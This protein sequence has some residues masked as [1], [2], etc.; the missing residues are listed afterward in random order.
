MARPIKNISGQSFGLLTVIKLDHTKNGRSYW[1][2]KCQCGNECIAARDSLLRGDTKSC[3]C[4]RVDNILQVSK[5]NMRH[6]QKKTRLY[7]IYHNMIQRCKNSNRNDYNRYGGR[8]ITVCQEWLDD[9]INFY[10]W[11]INSGYNEE[12]TIDR[13]DVNGNYEPNNCRWA[14]WEVQRLNKRNRKQG[15]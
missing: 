9:F 15:K 8:G 12:L 1:L 3:G 7:S 6:G 10:N 11:A 14:T 4:L 13:I 5:L 2:C